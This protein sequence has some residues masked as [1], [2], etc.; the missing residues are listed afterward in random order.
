MLKNIAY[1]FAAGICISLGGTVFLNCD[2]R[3][4]G[5]ILFAVALTCI[6]RRGY[7]LFTG[8]VG[9]LAESCQKDDLALVLGCLVG[10]T[11]ATV[12][13]GLLIGYAVPNCAAVAETLCS[14]KLGQAAAQ[15][16]IRAFFCGTLM[17]LAV[18]IYRDKKSP[19][20]IYYCVPVFI[21]SGFEHSIADM[22]YFAASG[23]VSL[24]AFKFL[25][26]VILG[27]AVGGMLL[28]ALSLVGRKEKVHE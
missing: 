18:S 28:P 20:G 12:A 15:T 22:F 10:N 2:N 9:F 17:Y 3:I 26:L 4:A 1:G 7:Y 5:S 21:L 13:G 11:L 19:D 24:A 25:W 14:G 16:F 27:N 23:I 8:K 6:C